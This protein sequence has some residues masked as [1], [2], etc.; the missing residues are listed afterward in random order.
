MEPTI[1]FHISDLLNI[2]VAPLVGLVIWILKKII[3]RLDVT[4]KVTGELTST[5]RI[6][7]TQIVSIKDDVKKAIEIGE[8]MREKTAEIV[9]MQRDLKTA[10]RLIDEL[11]ED[12]KE[13]KDQCKKHSL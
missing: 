6:I 7:E 2:V 1:S 3:D 4:S 11:K 12:V 13:C 9:I 10:F 8:E 5:T